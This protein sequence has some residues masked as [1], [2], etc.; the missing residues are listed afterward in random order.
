MY[1][2]P[3]GVTDVIGLECSGEIVEKG[4]DATKDWKV[5]DKVMTLLGG[6]GY[7]EFVAV[8]ER[9]VLPFR[10]PPLSRPLS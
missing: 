9:W 1:P 6:G 2:P 5:G 4:A 10:S 8:D 3:P 7:G